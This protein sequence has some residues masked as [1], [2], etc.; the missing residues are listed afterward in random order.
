MEFSHPDTEASRS[1]R[2]AI[3]TTLRCTVPFNPHKAAA[4]RSAD[5]HVRVFL[6]SDE[7]RADKAVRAPVSPFL[8]RT[9]CLTLLSQRRVALY[10]HLWKSSRAAT[11]L[12]S[13][14][15]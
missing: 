12:R 5:S 10:Q 6:A 7:V 11:I 2:S 8:E 13:A 4:V 15:V 14:A 9:L 1:P 3:P